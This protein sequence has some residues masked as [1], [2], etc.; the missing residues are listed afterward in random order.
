[1]AIKVR[2]LEKF[3]TNVR[4]F[5]YKTN[6]IRTLLKMLWSVSPAIAVNLV[7][8]HVFSPADYRT[9]AEEGQ[10]LKKGS[11]FEVDVNG[12]TIRGWKWGAGPG[13]LF[14]HGWNGRGIQL[15][16][17]F[18]PLIRAGYAVIA[19]DAPGHGESD[20]KTSSY[21]EWTDTVRTLLNPEHEF[22]II[23]MIGH[24]LGGSAIIN[25]LSKE[26]I[27]VPGVLIAPAIRLKDV[28]F[29]AFDLFGIPE[30]VYRKAIKEFENRFGYTLEKDD[31]WKLL[32][33]V[34]SKFLIVHDRQDCSIPFMDSHDMAAKRPNVMLHET[35][36]LGHRN[37]L[38]DRKI[39]ELATNY[40]LG[41]S[42][43]SHTQQT[44]PESNAGKIRPAGLKPTVQL[45]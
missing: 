33:M 17:F 44:A 10:I 35:I 38:R 31:P 15:F 7:K 25:A 37:I 36:G 27:S 8:K 39:V 9:G 14:V 3:S 16:R 28:L 34:K 23:G 40:I 13:I 6:V 43:P 1:M 29:N 5:N 21:F 32:P 11:K 26:D 12:K 4:Y 19:F 42:R 22:N 24:S 20:G 45:V 41:H 2:K 18:A 30:V